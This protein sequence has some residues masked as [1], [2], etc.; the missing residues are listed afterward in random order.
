MVGRRPNTTTCYNFIDHFRMPDI[1]PDWTSVPEHFKNNGYITLGGGKTFHPNL[2]P[3]YDEP[4]SWTQEQDY[5]PLKDG[6][7][8]NGAT[9][10]A[11]DTKNLSEF[12]DY[13][14]A[15][16]AIGYLD[17]AANST[18]AKPFFIAVGIRRPHVSWAVP[19]RYWD[20][21]DNVSISLPVQGTMDSSIPDIAWS[22]EAQPS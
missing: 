3:N 15:D 18:P 8:P 11:I 4:R 7:C 10:C 20:L 16:R 12:F 13:R 9:Y 5:Y 21:Y 22:D 2:P 17:I 14:M 6:N 1:G 19:S